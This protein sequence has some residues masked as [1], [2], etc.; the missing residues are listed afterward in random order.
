[1][2]FDLSD[3]QRLLK[4]SV[5]RMVADTY[6]F[7]T[8]KGV[9][10]RPEGWSRDNWSAF[11]EMGLLGVPFAEEHGGFGGGAVETMLVME[12]F[13]RGLVIEPY[14]ATVVMGG[15]LIRHGGSEA[16]KSEILPQVAAG[17]L[18][19]AFAQTERGSRYD[20]FDVSTMAKRDGESFV[21]NG[22]KGVVLHGES[23]DKLIVTARTAGPRRDRNG[24]G[25]FVVDANAPGLSRRGYPT[26]DGMRAAEISFENVRVGPEG[27]LGDP[28]HGL[29][30]VER[31]VDETIAA[32]A[33]EAVGAMGE[34]HATTVDYL[35]TRKQ[36]G[37]AIGSFQALQ[38]HAA[39]MFVALEQAR[40][41]MYFATMMAA[42]DSAAARGPAVSA[43]KVQ[44]GRS[45]RIVGQG[46]IQLHGGVG[47]TMEYKVGHYF[48]RLTMI[49]S[50]FGD[51][52]HH[53]TRVAESGGVFAPAAAAAA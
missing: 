38:H 46:A 35:K 53:L 44:L 14:L 16:Q 48:K 18:T 28:E 12:A 51:A 9:M 5:D 34:M 29:P 42:E 21:L 45:S 8:R 15:G 41:M 24:I 25:L 13:G 31:V 1:M 3:E 47:V 50:A 22:E 32:L 26:Q 4:D 49:E 10:A 43:A 11:A 19:L 30:V 17:D 36:F 20:L 39:D 6:D 52:D 37:V 33:A 27:V 2:D 23:A 40:S 7:E